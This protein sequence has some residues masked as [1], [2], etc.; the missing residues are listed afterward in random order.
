MLEDKPNKDIIE[1]AEDLIL[2]LRE[3][4]SA[5]IYA[6]EQGN[7]SEIHVV[8][9]TDRAPKL[10][11]RD[12]ESCLKAT[13]GLTIDYRKIGVVV[14]DPAKDAFAPASPMAPLRTARARRVSRYRS[15]A[16]IDD[17]LA[18]DPSPWNGAAGRPGGGSTTCPARTARTAERSDELPSWLGDDSPKPAE[19]PRAP[20]ALLE[21]LETDARV[22]FK[23]LRVAIEEDRVDVEVRLARGTLVVIG[24]QGDFR[25]RGRLAET[26]AGATLHAI[27]ELLDENIRLHLS[28]IEEVNLGSRMAHCAVVSAIVD[29]SAVSYVGC[30]IIGEERNE[31]AVLAVLDALNRPSA[32]GSSALKSVTRSGS[33]P[34]RPRPGGGIRL[35]APHLFSFPPDTKAI[36]CLLYTRRALFLAWNLLRGLCLISYPPEGLGSVRRAI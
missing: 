12:V 4:Q 1:R 33:R 35:R 27:S 34:G 23:G 36:Q 18:E 2:R 8:A 30:A 15:R 24:S 31:G 11:A 17:R 22:R 20:Q 32:G 19:S 26:I 13:L 6:D 28:G 5:R 14:I 21:F 9:V 3:V 25:F 29:R 16:R 7:I 10:I